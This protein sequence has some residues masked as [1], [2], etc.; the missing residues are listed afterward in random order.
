[1][2]KEVKNETV[3]DKSNNNDEFI[4]SVKNDSVMENAIDLIPH[5]DKSKKIVLRGKGDSIPNAVAIANILTER[6]LKGTSEIQKIVVDS[7]NIDVMGKMISTIE[8][9]VSKK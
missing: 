2:L 5:F 9:V 8:I 4:F 3:T 1:M 6:I 7:E